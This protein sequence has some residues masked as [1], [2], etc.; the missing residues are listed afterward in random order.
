MGKVLRLYLGTN[1]IGWAIVDTNSNE[2]LECGTRIFPSQEA[3]KKLARQSSSKL[4]IFV[5]TVKKVQ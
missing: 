3:N 2:L 5:E 1:S 4:K